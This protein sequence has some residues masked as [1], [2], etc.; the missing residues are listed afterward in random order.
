MGDW[1]TYGV[2]VGIQCQHDQVDDV[3]WENG[4]EVMT[5]HGAEVVWAWHQAWAFVGTFEVMKH[6]LK[7]Y[8]YN[9]SLVA[10]WTSLVV[11]YYKKHILEMNKWRRIHKNM[12]HGFCA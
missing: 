5:E 4:Q 10:N 2:D 11:P 8:A 9:P 1:W 12:R 7:E 6:E 3:V